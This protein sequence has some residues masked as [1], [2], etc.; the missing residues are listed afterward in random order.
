VGGGRSNREGEPKFK[1]NHQGKKDHHQGRGHQKGVTK[2][3]DD[4]EEE[5][6]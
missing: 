5:D 1:D 6:N 3:E 4:H 2:L